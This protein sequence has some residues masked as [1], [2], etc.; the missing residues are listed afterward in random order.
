[1]SETANR[2]TPD[3]AA[4]TSAVVDTAACLVA[5]ISAENAALREGSARRMTEIAERKAAARSAYEAKLTALRSASD[6]FSGL[7]DGERR[8]L[9]RA[10]E[11]LTAVTAE[12]LL[13]LKAAMEANRRLMDA[14]AEAL[15]AAMRG[16]GVYSQSGTVAGAFSG[17]A[18]TSMAVSVNRAL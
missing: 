3:V 8:T 1:M 15:R 5:A 4:L 10:G 14:V 11:Q 13:L 18:P 12:N 9:R 6:D 16:A 2:K 7:E 17:A